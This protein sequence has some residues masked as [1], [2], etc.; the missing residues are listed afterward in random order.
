MTFLQDALSLN[1]LLALVLGV[2][3]GRM[4]AALFLFIP[5]SGT[6]ARGFWDFFFQLQSSSGFFSPPGLGRKDPYEKWGALGVEMLIPVLYVLLFV[7]LNNRGGGNFPV[8]L[9]V[10]Y[11]LLI[12]ALVV[13]SA[14]DIRYMVLPDFLTLSVVAGGLLVSAFHPDKEFWPSFFG[15]LLGGGGL[16]LVSLC[17]YVFRREEGMGGGDIKLMAGLG[18]VLTWRA[19]PFLV[20]LSCLL[21]LSVALLTPFS[22]SLKGRQAIPFGPF[23]SVAGLVYLLYGR[24]IGDWYISVFLPL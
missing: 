20:L 3:G 7:C 22:K 17:Y 12:F 23:L 11:A 10:E 18:A 4:G 21:G 6:L 9:F 8:Y 24:Q 1:G 5:E 13:A 2:L 16:W 14:V 15:V 19:I